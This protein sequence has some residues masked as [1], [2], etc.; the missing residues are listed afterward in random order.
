M[1][2][3]KLMRGAGILLLLGYVMNL[4]PSPQAQNGKPAD[5]LTDGG[6]IERSAWQKE[7]A[8]ALHRERQKHEAALED[9]AR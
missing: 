3:R 7:R 6:D 2:E 8:P 1:R 4:S 9:E 5:W